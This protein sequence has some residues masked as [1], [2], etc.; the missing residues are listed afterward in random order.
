[1]ELTVICLIRQNGAEIVSWFIG[2]TI[3]SV[4]LQSGDDALAKELMTD[5]ARYTVYGN[6]RLQGGKYTLLVGSIDAR[7]P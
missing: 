6:Y 4:A 7:A 1:L 3:E 2:P 5:L